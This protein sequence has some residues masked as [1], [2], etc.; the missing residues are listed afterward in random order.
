MFENFKLK[1]IIAPD[2]VSK[3][4]EEAVNFDSKTNM[5]QVFTND[6][7]LAKTEAKVEI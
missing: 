3:Q 7:S 5:I 2:R 4:I 6:Y 1:K